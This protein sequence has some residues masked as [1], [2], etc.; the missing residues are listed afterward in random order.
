MWKFKCDANMAM[1][2]V[3]FFLLNTTIDTLLEFEDSSVGVFLRIQ[4]SYFEYNE[5]L[6]RIQL[7]L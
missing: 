1:S 6:L 4:V 3:A 7:V 2:D 5:N